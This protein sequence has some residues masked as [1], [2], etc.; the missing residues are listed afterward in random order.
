MT[1]NVRNID[2]TRHSLNGTTV[3]LAMMVAS[4][5]DEYGFENFSGEAKNEGR[6]VR[7]NMDVE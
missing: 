1:A 2:P 3:V 4:A 6:G 7:L 5:I